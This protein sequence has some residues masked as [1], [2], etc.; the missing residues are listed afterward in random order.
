MTHDAT[1]APGGAPRR[2]RVEVQTQGNA[3][4]LDLTGRV[5]EGLGRLDG[6]DAGGVVHLFVIG[7]TA[8]LT[9]VE[10][11]PGLVDHDV[12]AAFQRIVPDDIAY[13]HEATWNDDNGHSHVRATLVGPSLTV[14]FE[15]GG[16]LCLGTWQ[17]IVL[18]DFDTRP[19]RRTVVATVL[20]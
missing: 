16:E 18:I 19:R 3:E 7:S 2:F 13:R 11:E 8:A 5:R 4:L 10:Y 1:E 14:P 15:P 20:R 9:T 6:A 12:A 17:Q